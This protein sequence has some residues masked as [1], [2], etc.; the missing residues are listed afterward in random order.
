MHADFVETVFLLCTTGG[1]L[2]EGVDGTNVRLWMETVSRFY[3]M[4]RFISRNVET[5]IE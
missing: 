2:L 3:K 4:K 5:A 1:R